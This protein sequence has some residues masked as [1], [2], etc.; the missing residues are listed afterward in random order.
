MVME[1]GRLVFDVDVKEVGTDKKKVLNNRIAIKL[2]KDKTTFV[3]IVAWNGVAELIGK[4]YNKGNEVCV[5]GSLTNAKKK[6]GETEYDT[7]AILVDHIEFTHGNPKEVGK[8]TENKDDD[9]PF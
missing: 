6:I 9:L 3:D 4:M 5:V 2:N 1:I 8:E 7:V